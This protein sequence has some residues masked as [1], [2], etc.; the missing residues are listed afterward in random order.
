[1]SK[2]T[3]A[4]LP[5]LLALVAACDYGPAKPASMADLKV[6]PG[7]KFETSQVVATDLQ[8]LDAQGKPLANH[9]VRAYAPSADGKAVA[10]NLFFSGRTDANGKV[11]MPLRIP[12]RWQNVLVATDA[13]GKAVTSVPVTAGRIAGRVTAAN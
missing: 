5:A 4:I 13:D 8:V 3:L 7:F 9:A 6:P 1:M 12:A 2:K 10:G 11:A